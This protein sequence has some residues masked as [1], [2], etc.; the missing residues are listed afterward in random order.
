MSSLVAYVIVCRWLL[1]NMSCLVD[2]AII[3]VWFPSL[4]MPQKLR[5]HCHVFLIFVGLV[6]IKYVV[7]GRLCNSFR[8]VLSANCLERLV[9]LKLC[10]VV[11]SRADR[12]VV[13]RHERFAQYR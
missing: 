7:S 10:I 6:A 9:I 8:L 1:L 11:L 12:I 2:Y 4:S 5:M 13:F 3:S